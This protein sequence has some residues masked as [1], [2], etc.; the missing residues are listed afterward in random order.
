MHF[1]YPKIWEIGAVASLAERSLEHLLDDEAGELPEDFARIF[2]DTFRFEYLP[3]FLA[4]AAEAGVPFTEFRGFN[5]LRFFDR[6]I[7]G[8]RLLDLQPWARSSPYTSQTIRRLGEV[9][10]DLP[11]SMQP[12]PIQVEALL[13]G[14]FN[15]WAMYGLNMGHV[16][17][18][19]LGR[20]VLR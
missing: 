7:Q 18:H 15:T 11:R 3:Q 13:R 16:R 1:R 19:A 9:S 2:M 14:Y 10:R 17:S 6:P 4:P 8:E 20:Y 12:L 5:R